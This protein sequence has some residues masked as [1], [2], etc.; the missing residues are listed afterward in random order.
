MRQNKQNR[1]NNLLGQFNENNL[2]RFVSLLGINYSEAIGRGNFSCVF[3]TRVGTVIK[4][5]VDKSYYEFIKAC[6]GNEN[7]YLPKVLSDFGCVG[8]LKTGSSKAY[9]IYA[10]ELPK[11]EKY[12]N[13]EHSWWDTTTINY[14]LECLSDMENLGEIFNLENL[15]EKI[16]LDRFV[17]KANISDKKEF[18]KALFFVSRFD[19][20]SS[21]FDLH[22]DNVMWNV[23]TNQIV[24]TDPIAEHETQSAIGCSYT[25][26]CGVNEIFD[27]G[28]LSILETISTLING[29]NAK[30]FMMLT[31]FKAAVDYKFKNLDENLVKPKI[32][33]KRPENWKEKLD[34]SHD[35]LTNLGFSQKER[36]ALL[37]P[38][39]WR[40]SGKEQKEVFEKHLAWC[41][42][43]KGKNPQLEMLKNDLAVGLV[44]QAETLT[45]FGSGFDLDKVFGIQSENDISDRVA[46][47]EVMK[48]R[49]PLNMFYLG[50]PL[51]VEVDLGDGV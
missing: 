49:K 44:K 38:N 10:L 40:I 11:Y 1:F 6:R 5:T 26:E 7:I 51:R 19:K 9:D 25:N 39:S 4:F 50:K 2:S 46:R 20:L 29:E 48:N 32:Y 43:V 21:W 23:E 47:V 34:K 13:S 24:I 28:K 8:K 3:E 31:K 22:G 42:L 41:G 15:A 18:I 16:N 36:L 17:I 45:D 27:K 30:E 35:K 33:V 37:E 12:K 14:V